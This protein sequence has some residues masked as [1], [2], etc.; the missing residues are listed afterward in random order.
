M[1]TV[2]VR[3][4]F[5]LLSSVVNFVCVCVF[6]EGELATPFLPSGGFFFSFSLIVLYTYVCII[7]SKSERWRTKNC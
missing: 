1:H 7:C 5:L 4:F 3:F 2:K 6:L